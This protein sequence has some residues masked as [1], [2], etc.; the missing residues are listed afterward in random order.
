MKLVFFLLKTSLSSTHTTLGTHYDEVY[1]ATSAAERAGVGV[2]PQ[3]WAGGGSSSTPF[4]P[5]S[6]RLRSSLFI[7]H[8]NQCRDCKDRARTPQ[9]P[10]FEPPLTLSE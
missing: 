5:Q 8:T 4:S 7:V 9:S 3:T 1:A 6:R 2:A 10:R